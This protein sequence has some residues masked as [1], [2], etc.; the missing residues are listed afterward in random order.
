MKT[1]TLALYRKPW[2]KLTPK[3]KSTRVKALEVITASKRTQ[4]P[5]SIIA[6]EHNISIKTIQNNTNAFKKVNGK[7]VAKRFDIVSR[8]MLIGERGKLQSIQV[9]DSRHARTIGQY[10][11]AVKLY[12]DTGNSTKLKKFSKRKIKDSEGIVHSFET[13]LPTVEEIHERIEEIEFFEVYDS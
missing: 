12:L 6:R 3:Q 10:H 13:R 7:L 11:N 5:V 1:S 9:S 8:S 4:K 2:S